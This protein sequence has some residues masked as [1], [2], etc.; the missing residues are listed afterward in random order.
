M[1]HD[2]RQS[3]LDLGDCMLE[4]CGIVGFEGLNEAE[5]TVFCVYNLHVQVL[6]GGFDQLFFNTGWCARPTLDA[7][8][9]VD[10]PQT[11]SLLRQALSIF[12]DGVEPDIGSQK[13][14]LSP[15]AK[16]FLNGLDTQYYACN[17]EIYESMHEYVAA[18]PDDI[19]GPDAIDAIILERKEAEERRKLDIEALEREWARKERPCPQCGTRFVSVR[20]RGQCP[21]CRHTFLAS[22]PGTPEAYPYGGE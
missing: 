18:H 8:G 15:E 1:D 14:D 19:R 9:R 5:R 22:Q 6:N 21:A 2:A 12:P 16:T 17:E 7:L 3:I 4:L 10:L 11:A 20:N 13:C